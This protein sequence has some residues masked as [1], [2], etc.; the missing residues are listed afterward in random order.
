MPRRLTIGLSTTALPSS[1]VLHFPR[2]FAACATMRMAAAAFCA[3]LAAAPVLA[4]TA[5]AAGSAAPVSPPAS[6]VPG[7]VAA[8][9]PAAAGASAPAGSTAFAPAAAA[10]APLPIVLQARELH[11]RAELEIIAEGDAELRRGPL[12]IRADQLSYDTPDDLARALGHVHVSSDGNEFSG[13]EM[14]LHIERFSGFIDNPTYFFSRVGAGGHAARIDFLDREHVVASGASYSSC[15]ID[16]SGDPAWLLSS[17]SVALDLQANQGI[18]KNAVLRFY[19]VPI[20]AAGSFSFPLTD[21]RKSG[22]LPPSIALDSKSGLQLAVPY[23]W[24]IA[25]NRDATL[26]PSMS[27]RRGPGGAA[28]V[29]YLEPSFHGESDLHLL[30]Y[31]RVAGRSRYSLYAAHE[32]ELP[33]DT[34]LRL[35]LLHVSDDDYWK[36][37][38]EYVRSPTPRLLASDLQL[39]RPFG[40]WSTYA[41]VERWQVLQ[42]LDPTTRI[43]SP[44]ERVPQIGASYLGR[45]GGDFEIA[46]R[47]EFNRFANPT[48]FDGAPRPTGM[49]LDALG[50]I[51]RPFVSPGWRL[52]P[53][54]SFN[55]A[56][57]ALDQPLADGQRNPARVIP[58]FSLDSAWTFERDAHYFGRAVHQTLE[59]RLLYVDTPYRKQSELPNFDS[60]PKDFNFDSIFT[61]NAFSGVDRVS[62]AHQLTAG[63]TT[64]LIDPKTGAE[65]VR[66]GIAQR[67]LFR[68][69][70]VTPTGE[71]LTQ[72]FSDILLLGST[73]LVPRWNISSSIQYAPQTKT[74][75]Q[76]ITSVRYSP[77]PFRTV[78][79][80]YRL[81]RGLTSQLE[82][83]W[84][85]PVFGPVRERRAITSGSRS[86]CR[87][88]LYAVGRVNYSR[89]DRRITDSIA[90]FEYDAGCWIGRLV[91]ERLSTGRSEATTRLLLQLELV[92]LSSLGSNPLQVLKD[93]V[94]GY[95]LL[96]EDRGMSSS[97]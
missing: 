89:L 88:T 23:Y 4:Q 33:H 57:Y 21:A 81:D 73:T 11:G 3:V 19:G 39:T 2:P 70:L 97:P 22:W 7:S 59:P 50:S 94:P 44:Y 35:K 6:A 54:L 49:R 48:G 31:D 12:L 62:D 43:D 14:Q 53:K 76:S 28:Q 38:P 55:A 8:S 37:F 69:Q 78:S 96:R 17:D 91:A 9:A 24:N 20:L 56:S 92:G 79:V 46:F 47:G 68:D 82:F 90:G 1:H 15:P 52:V 60:A 30:P 34:L 71:P 93:N 13:P 67:Y 27:V 75:D 80:G 84:Q 63:V 86:N 66:L 77:G 25:P 10:S 26:T 18:A 83:G 85:W 29:R 45:Y 5:A 41:H 72:R 95:R 61:D 42:T 65:V 87:G 64:R 16:G 51:S 32:N 36:D 74:I 58:T 40:D